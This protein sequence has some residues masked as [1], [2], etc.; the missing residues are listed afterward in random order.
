MGFSDLQFPSAGTGAVQFELLFR[1]A[2]AQAPRDVASAIAHFAT[3]LTDCESAVVAWS[4]GDAH[5]CIVPDIPM[6]SAQLDLMR[7]ALA[8]RRPAYS[9]SG[10]QVAM[11]LSDASGPGSPVL[12]M[13]ACT[14]EDVRSMLEQ[15]RAPLRLASQ[16]LERALETV[17]LHESHERLARSETLQRAL[18]AISDLAGSDRDMPDLLRGIHAIVGTLMYAENFFIVLHDAG[19]QSLRF[20]YY[21]DV[22]DPEAPGDNQ[23]IPLAS[24]ERSLTWYVIRD[25]KALM[26]SAEQLA[27]QTSG[28]IALHGT[29]S[30]DW[31]GVPMLR[32]GRVEGALVVQN[33]QPGITYSDDDRSLLE[34]VGSH[35]LT[36][37]ERKQGKDDLEQHVRLRTLEL[38]DANEVLHAEITERQRAERLQR[39]LFQIAELATDDISHDDFYRRVHEVVGNLITATNF[40]IALLSDDRACLE[41]AYYVDRISARHDS[42]PLGRG[43]SEYVL[44]HGKTIL[45]RDDLQRLARQGELDLGVSGGMAACWLGVPLVVG[46]QNI[47]LIVVQSYEKENAYGPADLELLNF[48]ASQVANSLQRRRSAEALQTAYAQLERRVAERTQDLSKEIQERERAEE[49]LKHQVMHDHLT[50]LPNRAFLRERLDHMLL[51][52]KR[53]PWRRCALLYLDVDRFKVINDSL[54]HLAGDDVLK[55]VA[56]RLQ[57]CVREPDLVARLSGDEFAILLE[58]VPMPETAIKV[59]QRVLAVL[60][61]PLLV[62]GKQIEPSASVGIAIGD[63]RYTVAGDVLRDADAAMYRA[64]KQGRKRFEIFD[65]SLQQSAIDVL[66]ME[67]DLRSALQNDQFEPWFQPIV[68]LATGATVGFEALLRWNHPVRGTLVPGDFLQVA[69]DNGSLEAIDWRMFETSCRL[70]KRLDPDRRA[71]LTINVSPQHFRRPDFDERLLEL[72][73][74]SG[75]QRERLLVEITE[76]SLI[77][78]PRS[79]RTTLERL[80]TAG[81]GAALD[82]FGTGYSSLSYLHTFPLR[83][84]KIDRS[85]VSGMDMDPQSSSATIVAAV[86]AMARTLG[87]EVIAEGIETVEQRDALAAMGCDYGQGYLLGR[88]APVAHWTRQHATDA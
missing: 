77:D 83:I 21:A 33:Y 59:A 15:A 72:V 37:L 52:M 66:A 41:F 69:Q 63:S 84:L 73:D 47:G 16:H 56:R 2:S 35:I 60:G 22:E 20:L 74:A 9:P 13:V 12:L 3:R 70:A 54:G 7:S 23:P 17:A 46:D 8:Q 80:R 67:A 79:V 48:V 6:G 65:Q 28:P 62:A 32:D 68:R 36:A 24:M 49:Q 58:D 55:E 44:R 18:F 4:L 45:R 34:F 86:L 87:M 5:P 39:A 11:P 64:K 57:T 42:R 10:N 75:L 31:L 78:H 82:D 14:R 76:G 25:G 38:A 61:A 26:G 1:L 40:F 85:F 29:D 88:P 43:A 71:F 51:R 30:H 50:G 27:T 19:Q 53:E 81:I